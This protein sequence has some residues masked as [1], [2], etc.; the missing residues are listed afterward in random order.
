MRFIRNAVYLGLGITLLLAACSPSPAPAVTQGSGDTQAPQASPV[1]SQTP[2][3]QPRTLSICIG[4]EPQTLYLYGGSSQSMW[5]VLEAIYDGPIDNR[6]YAQQPVILSALPKMGDGVEVQPVTV[7]PGDEVVN[8]DGNLVALAKGVNV[9]PAGCN[10]PDCAQTYDGKS[11]L[12]MDEIVI[13][14]KLLPDLKWSDGAALTSADSVYSYTL[15]ADPATPASK[16]YVDR[17]T[18]YQ[19]VDTLTVKWTGKPGFTPASYA[20]LFWIPLPQH[21]W[22]SISA[23]DLLSSPDATQKPLGW[24]PYVIDDWVK[25][26]HITLSK[27]PDYFRA[28]DGL[29]KFDKLVFRFLS[30][31]TTGNVAGLLSGECDVVDESALLES[32]LQSLQELQIDG[33]LKI[34]VAQSPEWEHVDFGIKP[35]SYDDGYNP[36]AGD[37]P[38]LFG[39]PRT[40]QAFAYCMDRQAVV[41]KLLLGQTTVS[42]S[43]VPAQDPLY[44]SN[45]KTYPFSVSDGTRLLDEVGWKDTDNNPDTPRIAQGV[46]GVPDGTQLSVNLWTTQASL[47]QQASQILTDSL[48]QCGIG[49][50]QHYYTPDELFAEGPDGPMFGRKFDLVEFT[51]DSGSVPLCYLYESAQIPDAANHWV[52]ANVSGYSNPQYDAACQAAMQARPDQAAYQQGNLQAQEIFSN[53][54]PVVPLFQH[55][56]VAVTRKD[57]CGLQ[58]D[59]TARSALWNI[60][61]FD[62]GPDCK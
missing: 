52:G 20:D 42:N 57:F 36:A 56:L 25:G 3:P 31:N 21:A 32:Q 48:R 14:Y 5:S 62:Y 1:P 30:Q 50:T 6:S 61:A 51:W 53:D 24:G 45:V 46:K 38:D 60:E 59:P 41:D 13:T 12:Q 34:E 33:K 28:K 8:V 22:K 10:S 29:P 27:N 9:H 26:D 2:T 17:T 44:D 11:D 49:V 55:L 16:Y 19:A 35:A 4:Q 15:A 37:R 54:L 23:A 43:F 58:M 47:R 7:K 18:S 39:D 40:R